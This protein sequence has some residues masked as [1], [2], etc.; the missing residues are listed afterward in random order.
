MLNMHQFVAP[1][2]HQHALS[3]A[4]TDVHSLMMMMRHT[5][6][7][8]D[9]DVIPILD[10]VSDVDDDD[11]DED[12]DHL[13]GLSASSSSLFGPPQSFSHGKGARVFQAVLVKAVGGFRPSI[14]LHGAITE[15]STGS[16]RLESVTLK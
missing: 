1:L 15:H 7:E 12:D 9:I 13:Q 10:D 16:G 8:E 6:D 14:L 3:P 2:S 11:E 4:C 5:A